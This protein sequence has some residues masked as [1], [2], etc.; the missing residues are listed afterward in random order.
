MNFASP[1]L[2]SFL[3]APATREFLLW[4]L[5]ALLIGLALRIA[6]TI[7]MPWAFFHDDAADFLTTPDKLLNLHELHIHGKKTFLVPILFTIPFL[8]GVPALITIPLFQHFIGL[9]VVILVGLLCRLWFARWRVFIVPLTVLA[10]INPFYLWYEHTIMAETIFLFCTLL[11]VLAGALYCQEQTRGRFI[12][13]CAALFLEAG[14]RPEGKL[15]FGF[16]L[17][18]LAL[19]H[20]RSWRKYWPRL[21]AML[22]LAIT[23]H[24]LT[25]TSQAGLLLYTSVARLT[26]GNMK[27]APGFEP[28]IAPIR[29]ELQR[30]WEDE[31]LFP[32]VRDR[33]N[34]ATAVS[35]Y[36]AD[37]GA[38]KTGHRQVNALSMKLAAET[39]RRRFAQLPEHVWHKF[40]RPSLESPA[41]GLDEYWLFTKQRGAYLGS[42]EL[43]ARLS[44]GLFGRRIETTVQMNKWID[45][46]HRE[47]RWMGRLTQHWMASVNAL[48][49]SSD[50]VKHPY[51]DDTTVKYRGTPVYFV[52][53]AA[54][55]V[56]VALRRGVLQPFHIAWGLALLAFFYTIILTANV[57]PRFRYVLEP[58]WFLYIAII[59][60]V[61]WSWAKPLRKPAQ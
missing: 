58:F 53:A 46:H 20:W 28:Y 45:S 35:Q 23:T 29:K 3:R 30:R 40:R 59:A 37:T 18:L 57:R 52:A 8:T 21:A 49:F 22:A 25:R 17:F 16:G 4:C 39:C 43:V 1:R 5:P 38:R 9:C 61:L 2:Q 51:L 11:V 13:L 19:L 27:S 6:L 34:V 55:L 32:I 33:R 36:L 48:R 41:G 44:R 42:F 26:P 50:E 7:Q 54:G 47:V 10:A 14:A 24:F 56:L 31:R 12:F 60:D 15:L